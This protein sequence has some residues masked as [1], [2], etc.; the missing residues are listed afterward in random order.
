MDQLASYI[1]TQN[2][3]VTASVVNDASGSRLALVSNSS[4]SANNVTVSNLTGGIPAGSSSAISFTQITGEDASL[5]VDGIPID[6]A[7]NTVTGAVDGLTLNLQSQSP[8]QVNISVA[9]ATSAVSTAVNSFVSAYNTVVGDIN[10]QYTVNPSSHD[11]GPL[12]TDSNLSM[13]QTDLLGSP[14]YSAGSGSISTLADLGITMN[15]DG[16][17]T[18]DSTTLNNAIQNNF[19]GVQ[20]FLQGSSLNGFAATLNNQLDSFTNSTSGAFTLDLQSISTENTY[21]GTQITNFQTYLQTQQTLLTTEYTQA[22]INMQELPEQMQEI[23]TELGLNN[24]NSST[25]SA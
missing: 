25:T 6:S 11:E 17:L 12:A 13:L 18:V 1:N 4:G 7:S 2:L 23:D 21:L 10:A 19:S 22:D 15:N 20:N 16:T 9:Q 24:T 14:S 8:T 3:G 5:T